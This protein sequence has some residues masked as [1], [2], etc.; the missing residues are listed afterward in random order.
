MSL[1][2]TG[3]GRAVVAGFTLLE[4]MI[5]LAILGSALV[6]LSQSH[7]NS[8]RAANRA[9]MMTVAVLLARYKM[10][11]VE[12]DL[13]E[14]GFSEFEEV[15]K[16]DF[17]DEGF[18][19]YEYELRVDKVELPKNVD[20]SSMT[21]LFGGSSDSSGTSSSTSDTSSAEGGKMSAMQMVG[22]TIM[23]KQYQL[24]RAV[25]EQAIRRV[26]LKVT[27]KEWNR[28]KEITVVGY[29]TD[30]RKV[31]AAASGSLIPSGVGGSAGSGTTAA[32]TGN[33]GG[34]SFRTPTAN[35]GA[36]R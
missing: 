23:A 4:V 28:S 34:S 24:I 1:R 36:L 35:T 22:G 2:R 29:F 7:Q 16:G 18:D 5:S 25:L 3:R 9:K 19:R 27:W 12:D 26:Q 14:D 10:V 21:D 30:P 17:K 20:P 11:D 13:F 32:G 6:I 8:V 33:L 15:D 31:D